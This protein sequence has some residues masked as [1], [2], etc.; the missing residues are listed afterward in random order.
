MKGVCLS[1]GKDRTGQDARDPAFR[2]C[3]CTCV[4]NSFDNER[5]KNEETFSRVIPP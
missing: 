1:V 5:E 4:A 3:G 2:I